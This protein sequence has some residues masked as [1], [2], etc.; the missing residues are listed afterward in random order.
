MTSVTS[1]AEMRQA[2]DDRLA[3][4]VQRVQTY[5]RVVSLPYGPVVRPSGDLSRTHEIVVT[6]GNPFTVENPSNSREGV[7]ISLDVYNAT[8][9]AMGTVTFGD[10]YEFAG[11]FDAPGAGERRIYRFYRALP[12]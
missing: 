6:D 9:G 11:T 8:T 2:L 12:S 5:E 10:D 1:L 4:L 7:E 3:D